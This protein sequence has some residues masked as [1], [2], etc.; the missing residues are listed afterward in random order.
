M[1][2]SVAILLRF[3]V[4][5]LNADTTTILLGDA[6][7]GKRVT[8]KV[9]Y[10]ARTRPSPS[11]RQRS[12]RSDTL[13]VVDVRSPVRPTPL[14]TTSWLLLAPTR[15][16]FS[17]VQPRAADW[18]ILRA[19]APYGLRVGVE[20]VSPAPTLGNVSSDHRARRHVSSRRRVRQCPRLPRTSPD[21]RPS[22][23]RIEPSN[24]HSPSSAGTD[25]HRDES[26]PGCR[27]SS[28]GHCPID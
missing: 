15:F 21:D 9:T 17:T 10:N 20:R 13:Y 1:S 22:K 4:D 7:T 27:H 19:A 11:S 26:D 5:I 6:S 3:N 18:P 24:G 14:L 12:S 8:A 16:F 25:Q 23:R 28:S 2:R